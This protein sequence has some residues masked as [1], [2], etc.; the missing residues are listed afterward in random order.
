MGQE[1]RFGLIEKI[2]MPAFAGMTQKG[3]ACLRRHDAEERCP[4]SR[5]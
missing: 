3:D 4:P 1:V 5:A 2:E